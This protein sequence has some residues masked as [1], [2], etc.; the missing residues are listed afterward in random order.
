M[1]KKRKTSINTPFGERENIEVEETAK[2]ETRYGP[3]LCCATIPRLSDTGE[4]VCYYYGDTDIGKPV[5][6]NGIS[7]TAKCR[8][9]QERNQKFQKNRSAEKV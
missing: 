4:K 6:M 5:F 2:Q 9:D 8:R 7:A 1:N 3:V